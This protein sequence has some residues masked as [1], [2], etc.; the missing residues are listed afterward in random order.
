MTLPLVDLGRQYRSIKDEVDAAM[1]DVVESG[2]FIL[3]EEVERFEHEFAAYCEVRESVGVASGTA[4]I[5][6]ALEALGVGAGHEV[7]TPAN[8]F[9]ATVSPVIRLGARPVLVDCDPTTATLDVERAEA[10][11]TPRTKAVIAVHLYGHPADLDPLRDLCEARGVALVEDACQAHGARYKG[12]RAGSLGRVGAFS[13][14]PGKNLGA[15]GDGGAVTTDDEAL[16]KRVRLLRD[17]GQR[18]KYEHVVVGA[19]ERLDALQAAILRVKLR[20]LDGWNDLRRRH[21]QAY[22]ESLLPDGVVR[23]EEAPW[24]EHVWH[25]YVIRTR[26]RARVQ[27]ALAEEGVA[28]GMHYPTPLHLQKALAGLGYEPGDFP[29]TE[30]WARE[31]LSLPMF[32]ELEE[33]EMEH[34]ASL[35]NAAVGREATAPSETV[36]NAGPVASR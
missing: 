30:E 13:F 10:A 29:T 28:T 5:A 4:A 2:R 7:V 3:G 12:R 9:I 34:V 11:M 26:E 24:A 16:A 6:L 27:R 18:R 32:P 15:F 19:N 21:A 1:Q 23:P 36:R 33:T 14:Y 22:R 31:L 35:V 17:L 8:T 20:H 25:L